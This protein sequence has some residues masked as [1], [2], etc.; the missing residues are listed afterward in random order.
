MSLIKRPD[1]TLEYKYT[2]KDRLL[3]WSAPLIPILAMI[4]YLMLMFRIADLNIENKKLQKQLSV[5][6]GK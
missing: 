6:Q 4:A 1:G 2:W 3:T 5:C